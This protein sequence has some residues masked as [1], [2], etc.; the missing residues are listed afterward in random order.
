VGLLF[1]RGKG[2]FIGKEESQMARMIFVHKNNTQHEEI[3]LN[4]DLIVSASS[5]TSS[6]GTHT[7]V[8]MVGEELHTIT[9]SLGELV[10]LV[11]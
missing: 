9:E 3:L 4:A 2:I 11:K 7:S 5:N 6:G 10:S 1:G 8:R